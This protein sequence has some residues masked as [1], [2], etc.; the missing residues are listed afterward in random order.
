M[1]WLK[2]LIGYGVGFAAS[3]SLIPTLKKQNQENA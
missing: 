2:I 3:L 1:N